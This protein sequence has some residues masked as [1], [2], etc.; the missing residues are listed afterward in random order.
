MIKQITYDEVKQFSNMAKKDKV[1]L[2]DTETTIWFGYYDNEALVGVT[3]TILK[4]G[5]GRIR[6]VFVP[7]DHRGKGYGQ[8]LMEYIMKYFDKENACYVD[9][10]ASNYEWW[11]KK[12]WNLKSIVKNGAWV[13]KII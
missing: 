9:Q 5:K 1:N 10:L 2:K 7:K 6:G 11:L 8:T 12:G 4:H 3:G 13:Y